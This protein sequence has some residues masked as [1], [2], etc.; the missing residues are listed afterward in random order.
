MWLQVGFNRARGVTV[1]VK[2]NCASYFINMF[3]VVFEA[4]SWGVV[5]S[6]IS[7]ITAAFLHEFL[8]FSVFCSMTFLFRSLNI[9]ST[10]I[11]LQCVHGRSDLSASCFPLKFHTNTDQK[12]DVRAFQQHLNAPHV[13]IRGYFSLW[14]TSQTSTDKMQMTQQMQK[15]T[16]ELLKIY[17]Y[18]YVKYISSLKTETR[19]CSSLLVLKDLF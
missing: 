18:T 15:H 1:V 10:R 5:R 8:L 12:L 9:W 7:F 3:I 6:L 11:L 4:R 14:Q 16:S 17:F 2:S 19:E 13:L